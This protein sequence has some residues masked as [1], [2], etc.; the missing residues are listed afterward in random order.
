[1]PPLACDFLYQPAPAATIKAAGYDAVLTYLRV[2]TKTQVAAYHAAGLG[3]GTIFETLATEALGGAAKGAADGAL[4]RSQCQALGQP[5]GTVVWF[6]VADF[7]PT[8]TQIP[9]LAAYLRSFEQALGDYGCGPYATS[10]VMDALA[11]TSRQLW[12]QNA[13][14]DNGVPGNI[15]NSSAVLYQRVT[16][17][18]T[19]PGASPGSWDEDVVVNT[20]TIP[21]W[22]P[23]SKPATSPPATS[24][25]ATTQPSTPAVSPFSLT[26]VHVLIETGEGWCASPAPINQVASVVVWDQNP[27]VIGRYAAI[28]TF[29]GVGAS[30]PYTPD[31]VLVFHGGADGVYGVNVWTVAT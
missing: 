10:Y 29:A 12:W 1:M 13:E 11:H 8:P 18:L 2:L 25:P 7:Q 6:N 24:T 20:A 16:P 15:V 23:T 28:P 17:T 19:I 31:G 9:A 27:A 3:V 4:V 21:W 26:P 5:P 22:G 30:G 14:N